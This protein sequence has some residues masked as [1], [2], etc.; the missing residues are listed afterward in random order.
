[1]RGKGTGLIIL[2]ILLILGACGLGA[3]NIRESDQAQLESDRLSQSL[4]EK[5]PQLP[6]ETDP[7]AAPGEIA[8]P[9]LPDYVL[10]PSL[11]MPVVEV[12]GR[13]YVGM[14]SIPVL[15]L[16]LPVINEWSYPALKIAPCRYVGS[17]YSDDMII[18][19]HNYRSHFG[20][21][22]ELRP[23]DQVIFTD[24]DGN[25]FIYLVAELE[26]LERTAVEDME[27]GDWDLTLFTCTY[28]GRSRVTVRC[29]KE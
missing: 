8:V 16:E 3:Y 17:A 28:G 6:A 13:G 1:M 7:V 19:A 24:M 29:I 14:V 23:D 22:K 21:L 11:E 2:G 12:D 4:Q 25:V 15:G 5:I 20:R 9:T 27:A 10:F 26:T 18:M